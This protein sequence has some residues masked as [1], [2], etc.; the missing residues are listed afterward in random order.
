MTPSQLASLFVLAALWGGSFLFIR[1]AAPALGPFPLVAGRVLI[2]AVVLWAGMRALGQR[3]TL[4][5]HARKLVLLGLLNAS[6]PNYLFAY[7]ELHVTA[8]LAAI[9]NATVPLFGVGFG[10][11]WLGE[12]LTVRR[13]MGLLVGMA[14][15]GLVVGWTPVAM[16]RSTVLAIVAALLASASYVLATIYAKKALAGVPA[17]TLALG[18]QLGAAV[19]LVG[20]ALW[21]LPAA[22]PTA[23]ALLAMVALAVLSTAIA[24]LLFFRLVASVGPTKTATVGYLF[25]VFGTLWGALFLGEP[26][27]A[28]ML[29]G[30]ALI[31]GSVLLVNDV[32]LGGYARR[33]SMRSTAS[34]ARSQSRS[35]SDAVNARGSSPT[36]QR[37]P[38][39][40]PR[41]EMSG[42]PA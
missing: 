35:T 42:T 41:D 14:G 7:A 17:P 23:P 32:R 6:L 21:A 12:R 31:L 2:A 13:S 3:A 29:A 11:L 40:N 36:T 9:L 24:Y 22:R 27:N 20:P 19:W 37:L 8:S 15:V 34:R 4:R 10:I 28:M 25:P 26:V 30:L 1:I 38:T 39:T 5:P 33:F 16:T 18:Q